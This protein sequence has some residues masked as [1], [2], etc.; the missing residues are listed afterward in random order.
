MRIIVSIWKKDNHSIGR[1]SV[2]K[3]SLLLPSTFLTVQSDA[4]MEG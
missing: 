2:E 3:A 1:Q 4:R